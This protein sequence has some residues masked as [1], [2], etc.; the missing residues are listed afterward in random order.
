MIIGVIGSNGFIGQHLCN[1]LQIQGHEVIKA[2]LPEVDI[3]NINSFD[4]LSKVDI[5]YHL[6]V[7]PLSSCNKDYKK[8]IETNIMGTANLMTVAGS[9]KVKRIIYAS[10]SSVYGEPESLPAHESDPT[11]P[12]TMYGM[13]KL[14]GENVVRIMS[15]NFD[16]TYGIFRFTNVYGD[17]QRNGIIPIVIN[18]LLNGDKIEITGNGKQTRDFVHV[19]DIVT[20]LIKAMSLP[21]YSFTANLGSNHN[22]SIN[23]IVGLCSK[24]LNKAPIVKNIPMTVDR[25]HFYADTTILKDIF[26][27]FEFINFETGLFN[28]INWWINERNKTA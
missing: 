10:A 25:E 14:A 13:S 2:D 7:L 4:L 12:L 24:Y 9:N 15:N 19:D 16:L 21:I 28:T 6:A 18:K 27:E 11:I 5:I 26:G 23:D 1:Q 17:G 22:T 3:T 20:F 8:C